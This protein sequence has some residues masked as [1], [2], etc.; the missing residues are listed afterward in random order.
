LPAQWSGRVGPILYGQDGKVLRSEAARLDKL[1]SR[2]PAWIIVS[3]ELLQPYLD[4]SF[5]RTN[6]DQINLRQIAE[7]DRPGSRTRLAIYEITR[8]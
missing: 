2:T 6:S 5:G 4:S 7:F 3:A 1:L 8:R